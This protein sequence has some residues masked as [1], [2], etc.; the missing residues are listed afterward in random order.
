MRKG[1]FKLKLI[2]KMIEKQKEQVIRS[3]KSELRNDIFSNLRI[4]VRLIK[5][6]EKYEEITNEVKCKIPLNLIALI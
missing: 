3:I 6:D 1:N 4:I 2:L 5:G